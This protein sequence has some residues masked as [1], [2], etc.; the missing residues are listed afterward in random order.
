MHCNMLAIHPQHRGDLHKQ[1]NDWDIHQLIFK[2]YFSL[3]IKHCCSAA[4]D[5]PETVTVILSVDLFG[6][7][8]ICARLSATYPSS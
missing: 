3:F 1:E 2:I 4:I 6:T 5:P 8:C 7:F